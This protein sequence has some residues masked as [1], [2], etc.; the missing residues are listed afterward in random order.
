MQHGSDTQVF[1]TTVDGSGRVLVPIELRHELD[2]TKGT[3]LLWVKSAQGLQLR[4]FA[5]SL[6][7]VQDYY[8]RLAPADDVWSEDI[9]T[10]RK[11]E[12][13]NE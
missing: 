8:Q 10:R 12:A 4:T 7:D 9:I 3:T 2:A 6:A 5:Q 11:R 13:A 1:Q